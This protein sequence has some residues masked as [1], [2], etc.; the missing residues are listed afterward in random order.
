M[1]EDDS[2]EPEFNKITPFIEGACIEV[3]E[4]EKNEKF[5]RYI[6]STLLVFGK[7]KKQLPDEIKNMEGL[8]VEP[9]SNQNGFGL[10]IKH[11]DGIYPEK[12]YY[13]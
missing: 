3:F 11:R 6:K 2:S 9:K 10:I 1:I 8:T 4:G 5:L 7:K 13:F 12:E